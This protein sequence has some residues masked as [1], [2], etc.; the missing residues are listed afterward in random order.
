MDQ[1]K[2]QID[3]QH[4]Y[5]DNLATASAWV[6]NLANAAVHPEKNPLE[7]FL[8]TAAVIGAFTLANEGLRDFRK[9]CL[10]H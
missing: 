4:Q 9:Y 3:K 6:V 10:D 1:I 5:L 7:L 2:T 8:Y